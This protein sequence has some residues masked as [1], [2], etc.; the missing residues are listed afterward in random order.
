MA[1]L[2]AFERSIESNRVEPEAIRGKY[3][4]HLFAE[5][6]KSGGCILVAEQSGQV[7]GF[8]CVLCRVE[9]REIVEK[10]R[11]YAYITDLVVLDRHRKAG[12]GTELMR[13]AESR[14]FS[15]GATR[16]RIGVLAAN[17]GAHR[18]YH[19]LGYSDREVVLEKRLGGPAG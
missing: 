11:E 4:D 13:A 14:A 6:A 5:C 19:K 17:A 9:S 2:Q 8:V 7:V 18:L 15:R 10:E 1:E 12:I 16:I 3:V